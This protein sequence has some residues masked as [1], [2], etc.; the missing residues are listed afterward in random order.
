MTDITKKL[1]NVWTEYKNTQK[2]NKELALE[3]YK[4]NIEGKSFKQRLKNSFKIYKK[5]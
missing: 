5:K 2:E 4:E 1:K 3:Y